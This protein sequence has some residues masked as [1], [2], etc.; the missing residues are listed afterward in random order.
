[1]GALCTLRNSSLWIGRGFFAVAISP[2]SWK[3]PAGPIQNSVVVSILLSAFV[4]IGTTAD[5]DG[6]LFDVQEGTKV[7]STI[8]AQYTACQCILS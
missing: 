7:S 8:A 2:V 4:S 3:F 5:I 6:D 1:M